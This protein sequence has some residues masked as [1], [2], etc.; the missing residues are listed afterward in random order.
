MV[1]RFQ[2]Y[3]LQL[4][5]YKQRHCF[6]GPE[7]VVWL[8]VWEEQDCED[9]CFRSSGDAYVSLYYHYRHGDGA[10][11][12][13]HRAYACCCCDTCCDRHDCCCHGD[14]CCCHDDCHV[15]DSKPAGNNSYEKT[16]EQLS[17][18]NFVIYDILP[19][20]YGTIGTFNIIIY[21]T[22]L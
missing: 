3:L 2:H 19:A 9:V 1:L 8:E 11:H 20:I 13:C 15:W 4:E 7:R 22:Q 18:I 17:N 21:L 6:A 14:D 10:S 5:A 16:K 12:G